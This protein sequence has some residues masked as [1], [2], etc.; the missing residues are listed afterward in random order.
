MTTFKTLISELVNFCFGRFLKRD[1]FYGID[2][3]IQERVGKGSYV[4]EKIGIDYP[5]KRLNLK[6]TDLI[7]TMLTR[8]YLLYNEEGFIIVW[9]AYYPGVGYDYLSWVA[10]TSS[11][12]D[13]RVM[14]ERAS[15]HKEPCFRPD[16]GVKNIVFY[17]QLVGQSKLNFVPKKD[18]FL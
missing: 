3:M 16:L 18:L 13:V 17:D 15:D 8:G 5:Q 9:V 7:E 11:G 1:P 10:S 4:L 14:V 6:G 12:S 2:M